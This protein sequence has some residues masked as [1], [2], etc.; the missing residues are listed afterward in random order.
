MSQSVRPLHRAVE[1]LESRLLFAQ[2]LTNPGAPIREII[3]EE[4]GEFQFKT[5]Q[6]FTQNAGDGQIYQSAVPLSGFFVRTESG[7]QTDGQVYGNT[8][9]VSSAIPFVVLGT[10]VVRTTAGGGQAIDS[11]F[12]PADGLFRIDQSVFYTPGDTFFQVAH[13]LVNLSPNTFTYSVF[14]YADVN[15]RG[16]GLYDPDLGA[17][18]SIDE[19]GQPSVV[20]DPVDGNTGGSITDAEFHEEGFYSDIVN[21]ILTPGVDLGFTPQ[22]FQPPDFEESDNA[23]AI[24]WG[25][26]FVPAGGDG[27]YS[28]NLGINPVGG[29]TTPPPSD[30]PDR[31]FA[32]LSIISAPDGN[33][34]TV[35]V[36]YR[37]DFASVTPSGV[38]Q[39]TISLN[40]IFLSGPGFNNSNRFPTNVDVVDEGGGSFLA[41][42][43]FS[44]TDGFATGVYD[45]F[46][47][48]GAVSDAAGN[49]VQLEKDTSADSNKLGFFEVGTPRL[50]VTRETNVDL[51]KSKLLGD[52]TGLTITSFNVRGQDDGFGDVSTGT[53]VNPGGLY[54]LAPGGGIVISTGD[55]GDFSS[56]PNLDITSGSYSTFADAGQETLLDTLTPGTAN[57]DYRDVTQIDI[58]F[59][60]AN[61]SQGI[62]FDVVYGTEEFPEFSGPDQ[63][64]DGFGLFLNGVNIARTPTL[65]TNDGNATEFINAANSNLSRIEGTELDGIVAVGGNPVIS[66]SNL[67]SASPVTL[68]PTGNTLTFIIADATDSSFPTTAYISA[69]G[70][71]DSAPVDTSNI[72]TD[73]D[74]YAIAQQSGKTLAGGAT[75]NT[76]PSPVL[77]RFSGASLDASFGSNGVAESLP[78]GAGSIQALTLQGDKILAAGT[79]GGD[80]FV[81]RY[82]ANGT[83]DTTFG[84]G[85]D[86]IT[87]LNIGSQ[88]D[89]AY[90]IALDSQGRILLAGVTD[91][92]L[93]NGKTGSN[94]AIARFTA[95]GAVDTSF[96]ADGGQ[97]VAPGSGFRRDEF[98]V[99]INRAGSIAIQGNKFIVAG[100][101][102]GVVAVAR[103]LDTGELDTAGATAGGFDANGKR[104]IDDIKTSDPIVG[105]AV[106]GDNKIL[107][108]GTDVSGAEGQL[109]GSNFLMARL[110]EGGAL[111]TTFGVGGVVE[112]NMG[113]TE[114]ADTILIGNAGIYL[115]GTRATDKADDPNNVIVNTAVALY[116]VNGANTSTLGPNGYVFFDPVSFKV[117]EADNGGA[118]IGNAF[119]DLV[120]GIG[121]VGTDGTVVAS[122]PN[123]SGAG[124]NVVVVAD[125]PSAPEPPTATLTPGNTLT[126]VANDLSFTVSYADSNGVDISDVGIDD[127]TV[128]NG[129]VNLV[130]KSATA[131]DNSDGSPRLVIYTVAPADGS[132]NHLDS[133]TYTVSLAANQITDTTEL[134]ALAQTLGTFTVAIPTPPPVPFGNG[135]G[136]FGGKTKII[137]ADP[138]TGALVTLQLNSG[139]GQAFVENG[140]IKIAVSGVT[141]K[142]TLTV[143]AKGGVA[144][145]DVAV[146]GS[147][148][149]VSAKTADLAGIMSATGSIGAVTLASIS[150]GTIVSAG[151][152]TGL[153]ANS[154]N[155]GKILAGTSFGANGILGGGDDAFATASITKI[156]IKGAVAGSV[157]SAG[158]NPGA[159]GAYGTGDDTG[160][161]G[162][163][164]I[165]KN[166]S[167]KS[168]TDSNTFFLAG[169]FPKT[170]KIPAKVTPA[171]GTDP[172]FK[173][174]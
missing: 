106:Q 72:A 141:S 138:T 75:Q 19:D 158:A 20:L 41:T 129:G 71:T 83:L 125:D 32:D 47:V 36:R 8:S 86:G 124:S 69:L 113:G 173:V 105:L 6:T 170:V 146:S 89:T 137:A 134:A 37:D 44:R 121:S 62:F 92:I 165:I 155:N 142:S 168:S 87:T 81:A 123:I 157:F 149:S 12:G 93:G 95:N 96:N 56:G 66:F 2:T 18:A 139:Q 60:L 169:A 23:V 10:Q 128:S 49:S 136:A 107:V 22:F 45:I 156:A 39:A 171:L 43:T 27:L 21:K 74:V 150:G 147:L 101:T 131:T 91:V 34:R 15:P 51:L 40:D 88:F 67:D 4:T 17:I 162:S 13:R 76:T 133:G 63:F 24:Q 100:E 5:D 64:P 77:K 135:T 122:K 59:D 148:K 174:V 104:V 115:L 130:V 103:Y 109:T 38:D 98:T 90:T 140:R 46:L 144:L 16:T 99:G 126:T 48:P 111:D 84:D 30:D 127:I 160:N 9:V 79:A 82:N 42:Y 159:D 25:D 26:D 97:G 152:I 7:T 52:S 11:S 68:L 50:T 112:T 118:A 85:G 164:S 145:G 31:P 53:Y 116:G 172:R 3:I 110:T 35:N 55:A 70:V 57:I 120:K 80:F 78:V 61:I 151:T 54:G 166:L 14:A 65:N 119:Q 28:F 154:V 73:F 94:F 58:T 153:T 29:G 132:F 1:S 117:A 163:S 108:A 114:D 167:I 102:N 33:T 143:K 161:G